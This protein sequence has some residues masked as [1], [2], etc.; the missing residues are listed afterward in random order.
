MAR[1]KRLPPLRYGSFRG[2]DNRRD[3]AE[4]DWGTPGTAEYDEEKCCTIATS[5]ARL[6]ASEEDIA[7]ALGV[8]M[9][10]FQG[11]RDTYGE[12]SEAL[13]G[14]AEWSD[15][16]LTGYAVKAA[17][18]F[19]RETEK[20]L[21]T[22]E[23]P[24]SVTLRVHVPPLVEAIH[25]LLKARM[26]ALYGDNKLTEDEAADAS[27]RAVAELYLRSSKREEAGVEPDPQSCRVAKTMARLGAQEEHIAAALDVSTETVRG[28]RDRHADFA[29][30]LKEGKH[31]LNTALEDALLQRAVGYS[32]PEEEIICDREGN[33]SRIYVEKY[34]LPDPKAGELWRRAHPS[35][36]LQ[37]AIT[38][39][40]TRRS[41]DG[42]VVE[43]HASSSARTKSLLAHP[44]TP[45]EERKSPG[46]F[47]IRRR[48]SSLIKLAKVAD[49]SLT[50]QECLSL[51]L[52][53]QPMQLCTARCSG[54]LLLE[55]LK[56]LQL[57]DQLV[58]QLSIAVAN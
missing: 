57:G 6:G 15:T 5:L 55:L 43:A 26:P 54:L 44:T 29:Q 17:L 58:C 42:V 12:F 22:R 21:N 24:I 46:A 49:L 9:R 27:L 1:R 20:V 13:S 2:G 39:M 18:G 56:K 36:D 33:V 19:T 10:T 38:Q 16:A 50:A 51:A 31:L 23:G 28:W 3:D 40:R 53:S 47:H 34:V 4:E 37:G 8:E 41:S 7:E 30:A 45:T 25:L 14:R 11:W 52:A 35:E 48:Q 32:Y